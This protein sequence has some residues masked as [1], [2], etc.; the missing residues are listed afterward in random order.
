MPPPTLTNFEI[1]KNFQKESR[2][3]NV[4]LRV[5]LPKTAGHM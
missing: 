5:N 2:F 4:Y 1:Q 3:N